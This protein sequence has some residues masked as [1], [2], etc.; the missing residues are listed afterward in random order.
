MHQQHKYKELHYT[1]KKVFIIKMQALGALMMV[2]SLFGAIMDGVNTPGK[3][4]SMQAEI[5]SITDTTNSLAANYSAIITADESMIDTMKSQ[6]SASQTATQNSMD[7]LAELKAQYQ[8]TQTRIQ[9]YGIMFASLLF[10]TL[11]MKLF[12]PKGIFSLIGDVFSSPAPTPT[13]S[14]TK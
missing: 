5:A 1:F 11:L 10:F 4:A 9:L 7:K 6:I 2:G 13:A 14:T 3:V 8:Q 12:I